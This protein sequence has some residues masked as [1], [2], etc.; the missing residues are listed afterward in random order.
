MENNDFE[1]EETDFYLPTDEDTETGP[2]E[3]SDFNRLVTFSA[4]WTT[5]TILLQVAKKNIDLN[6]RFQ[7]R[8]AWREKKKS[9]FVESLMLGIPVPQLVF[10]E[11]E[12][13]KFHVIDGKQRILAIYKFCSKDTPGFKLQDLEILKELNGKDYDALSNDSAHS[14][15]IRSFENA[16]IRCAIIRDCKKEEI[17]RTIFLR[18][19]TGSVKLSP[20]E[21]RLAWWPG[22]FSNYIDDASTNSE[23]IK[24]LLSLSE[25]DFRMRDVEL[26]ARYLAFQNRSKYYA[27]NMSGFIND[28]YK[29]FNANEQIKEK[30][31]LQII[32]FE[33]A[34]SLLIRLFTSDLVARNITRK[35]KPFNRAL[36]DVQTYFFANS[37]IRASI[38]GHEQELKS[39]VTELLNDSAF[40]AAI[41][42][43]TKSVE[44]V[45]TRFTMWASMLSTVTGTTIE[46]PLFNTAQ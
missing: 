16:P 44:A 31:D 39:K 24:S 37:G 20:Q 8:D 27:G 17:L 10:A 38:S 45:R 21:L 6:P 15:Y 22:W 4:D 5:E 18:L 30:L 7:R 23:S 14:D 46:A 2:V 12:K 32:E 40:L 42:K 3:V 1:L 41:E 35:R 29:V 11:I 13:G 34:V 9:Q 43:T 33:A 26:L 36:F 28:A 25:P 19:N